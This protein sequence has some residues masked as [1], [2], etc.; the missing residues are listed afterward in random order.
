MISVF[1][2]ERVS[3]FNKVI[4][5]ASHKHAIANVASKDIQDVLDQTN[6]PTG[7]RFFIKKR[8]N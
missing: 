5:H 7:V 3:K 1:K 2:S 4:L 8:E 6:E